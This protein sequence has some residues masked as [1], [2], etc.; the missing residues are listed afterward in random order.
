MSGSDVT[1]V[2]D[3]KLPGFAKYNVL[4]R[5]MFKA[6]RK[7]REHYEYLIPKEKLDEAIRKGARYEAAGHS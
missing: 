3:A 7:T 4:E 6:G 1:V 5:T 2:S